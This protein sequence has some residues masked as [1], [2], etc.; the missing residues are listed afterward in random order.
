MPRAGSH[1]SAP[2]PTSIGEVAAPPFALTP[3]PDKVF[4]ARARRFADLAARGDDLAPYLLFLSGLCAAQA[5]ILAG[6]PPVVLPAEDERARSSRHGMPQ[7]GRTGLAGDPV[8]LATFDALLAALDGGPMPAQTQAAVTRLRAASPE[9]RGALLDDALAEQADP[10]RIAET[11]LAAAALQVHMT[12]MAA[13]LDADSL[14]KVANGACPACG[15]APVAS[16]VVGREGMANTRF[17][18]CA[19]CATEWHVVRV[20]CLSCGNERGLVFHGIEGGDD[21]VKAET[22]PTC[23]SYTKIVY[24]NRD[25]ALDPLADDVGSL[26]LDLMLAETGKT[27]FSVNPFLIGY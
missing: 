5:G 11:V 10:T 7:L 26:A 14:K 4:A 22:C 2:D 19:L 25:P 27:R 1:S 17:C 20:L 6:L 18:T 3:N 13:G 12:R 16:A 15:G 8:A 23:S 9:S 21:N 24:Q